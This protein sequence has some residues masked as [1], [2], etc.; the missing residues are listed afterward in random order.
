MHH[1]H[2]SKIQESKSHTIR[3]KVSDDNTFQ[4]PTAQQNNLM[5]NKEGRNWIALRSFA[6]VVD[7]LSTITFCLLKLA[8]HVTGNYSIDYS[9]DNFFRYSALKKVRTLQL[10]L[11]TSNP[12]NKIRDTEDVAQM[13]YAS[14]KGLS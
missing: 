7:C 11:R 1:Y 13:H 8:V 9:S 4:M 12:G 14:R 3:G 10:K 5:Q 6:E 2:I